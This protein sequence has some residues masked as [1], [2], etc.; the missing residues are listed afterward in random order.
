L[1]NCYLIRKVQLFPLQSGVLQI[2]PVEVENVVRFIKVAKR[3]NKETSTWL[4]AMMEKMQDAEGSNDILEER[5]ILK[6]DELK[7]NVKELP[8]KYKPESFTGAVGN[9]T[10]EASLQHNEIALNDNA[11]L[12]VEIKGTGNIPMLTAPVINWPAGVDSFEAKMNEVIDKSTSPFNG[13]KT[14]DFP[15]SVS[16]TGLVHIPSISFSFFND[17]QSAYKTITTEP[18]QLKVIKA[19]KRTTP[20]IANQQVEETNNNVEDWVWFA[21]IAGLLVIAVG[22]LF[23]ARMK[24]QAGKKTELIH[25]VNND[26]E[27]KPQKSIAQYLHPAVAFQD[28]VHQQQFYTLL[29]NGLQQFFTDRMQLNTFS[30]NHANIIETLKQKEYADLVARYQHITSECEMILFSGAAMDNS[31][32]Q[33]LRNAIELM[34]EA[35]RRFSI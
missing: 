6:S 9:F 18:L 16:D 31:K 23:F 22:F 10:M 7:V 27:I 19:I 11:I 17:S 3:N 2:E 35:D 25:S 14:F 33:L 28:G 5:F 30:S 26:E 13:S 24:K 21:G 1:Y 8:E 4:D 15:F 34:T 20:V 12:H 29:V 32:D